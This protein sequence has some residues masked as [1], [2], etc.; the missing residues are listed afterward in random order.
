MLSSLSRPVVIVCDND[1]PGIELASVKGDIVIPPFDDLASAGTPDPV[2]A[3]DAYTL[4]PVPYEV[5]YQLC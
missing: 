1:G 3:F 2:F 4:E 5:S